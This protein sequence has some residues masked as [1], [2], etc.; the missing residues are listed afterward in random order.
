MEA[1]RKTVFEEYDMT[2]E[3]Y[4][5][6]RWIMALV[7]MMGDRVTKKDIRARLG[8]QFVVIIGF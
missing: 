1:K 8:F 5:G 6:S 3:K 4:F 7:T 2:R